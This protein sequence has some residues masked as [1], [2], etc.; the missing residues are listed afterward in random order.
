ML[1]P[2]TELSVIERKQ[3]RN[4]DPWFLAMRP[5]LVDSSDMKMKWNIMYSSVKKIINEPLI[6]K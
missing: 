5:L 6:S 4:C 1:P 2:G 3:R